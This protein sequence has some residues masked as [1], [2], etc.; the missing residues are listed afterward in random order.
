M[1]LTEIF[2]VF[3][4]ICSSIQETTTKKKNCDFELR[5]NRPSENHTL[6]KGINEFSSA[7]SPF[8]AQFC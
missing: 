3:H 4:R 7:L 8:F 2:Y 5:E 6:L 1:Q